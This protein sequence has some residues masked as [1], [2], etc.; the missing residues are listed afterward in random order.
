[1]LVLP[2]D[3]DLPVFERPPVT[4]LVLGVQFEPLP[5]QTA[6][7]GLYWNER[8][9]LYPKVGQQPALDPVI[10][11]FGTK[12]VVPPG[13][14]APFKLMAQFE[15]PRCWYLDEKENRVVQVQA[16]RL[17]HNW[18]KMQDADRDTYP[19]YD[20][21]RDSFLAELTAFEK[22]LSREELG[23][24]KPNQCEV[25]Y[26]NQIER[27]GVWENFG[28]A[29]KVFS[30]W[31]PPSGQFLPPPE[32]VRFAVRYVIN[33]DAGKPVGRLHLSVQPAYTRK[34]QT[35]VFALNL[36]ARGAPEGEGIEGVVRFLDRG[37][38]SIVL[39]FAELTTAAMHQ[40]WGRKHGR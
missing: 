23:A 28:Q 30:L 2:R 40:V 39:G 24:L 7:L 11:T 17:V 29:H 19:H 12:H 33:D 6:H 36:M 27:S 1:M 15:T 3:T 14:D 22:F 21:M 8:R 26:V 25:T 10:E 18:R 16:D 5:I 38:R 34:D 20:V 32:D 13:G 4:E 37:H 31:A 9:G 35:E